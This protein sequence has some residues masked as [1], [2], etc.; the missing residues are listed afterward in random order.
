MAAV[1]EK[2][3]AAGPNYELGVLYF[4]K[5]MLKMA[6]AQ[7]K[8]AQE[9]AKA[10]SAKLLMEHTKLQDEIT[11]EIELKYPNWRSCRNE[12]M[13]NLSSVAASPHDYLD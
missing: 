10:T 13:N 5:R 3:L 8:Y 7:L 2:P 1:Q 12:K 4:D 11:R 9:C 6:D